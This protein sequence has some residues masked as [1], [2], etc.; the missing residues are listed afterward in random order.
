PRPRGRGS[1]PGP[2][3]GG[4]SRP[5]RIRARRG[6][7]VIPSW[8]SPPAG[9]ARPAGRPAGTRRPRGR[10]ARDFGAWAAPGSRWLRLG[11]AISPTPLNLSAGDDTGKDSC[12]GPRMTDRIL[13][14]GG[15][16]T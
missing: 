8:V 10:G 11:G 15:G 2:R 9:G 3:R 4:A 12:T 16:C 14:K 13:T 7:Q 1:G 6:E 5:S